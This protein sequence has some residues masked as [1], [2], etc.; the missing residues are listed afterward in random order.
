[1]DALEEY[2]DGT[3][4]ADHMNVITMALT[5]GMEKRESSA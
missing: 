3:Y 4:T 2:A 1:M 5:E